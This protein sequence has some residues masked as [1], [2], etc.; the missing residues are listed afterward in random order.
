MQIAGT[1]IAT[2]GRRTSA[3]SPAGGRGAARGKAP[4][5]PPPTYTL[6]SLATS[7]AFL[8]VTLRSHASAHA[9]TH[10]VRT[11]CVGRPRVLSKLT[12]TIAVQG[13]HARLGAES[14]VL[15][16]P[17]DALRLIVRHMLVRDSCPVRAEV[18]YREHVPRREGR[19]QE[20]YYR[21]LT[22]KTDSSFTDYYEHLWDLREEWVTEGVSVNVYGGTYMIDAPE[23]HLH[24]TKLVSQV[25][26]V[27]MAREKL[28]E[29]KP[30]EEAQRVCR[31]GALSAD[32]KTVEVEPYGA[33][34][35]MHLATLRS[36]ARIRD[37]GGGPYA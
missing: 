22:L 33:V 9:H 28:D 20:D 16:L 15:K 6:S 27:V 34:G 4:V 36:D 12:H 30:L 17:P 5:R 14:P 2:H 31:T 26:D 18:K 13:A 29:P 32:R 7:Y 24:Y 1:S 8:Q 11:A 10:S 25:D 19:D 35:G 23:L 21:T 37:H 3:Q